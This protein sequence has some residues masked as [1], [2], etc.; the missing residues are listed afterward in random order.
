MCSQASGFAMP[1]VAVEPSAILRQV[2]K[3]VHEVYVALTNEGFTEAQAL[4][5]I[6]GILTAA[7]MAGDSDA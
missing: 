2:A 6:R 1:G 7:V 5:V 4:Y 3:F